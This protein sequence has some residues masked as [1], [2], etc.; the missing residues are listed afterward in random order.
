[1]FG[2]NSL[3]LICLNDF[4]IFTSQWN[5]GA[6][7]IFFA[8]FFYRFVFKYCTKV[9][10]QFFQKKIFFLFFTS[11]KVLNKML[12]KSISD[13]TVMQMFKDCFL[14]NYLRKMLCII[15]HHFLKI[16][17]LLCVIVLISIMVRRNPNSSL[18][19]SSFPTR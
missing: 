11:R 13:H 17:K 16:K 8:T 18:F 14:C 5:T 3:L 7:Q 12:I 4:T 9:F 2:S 19:S 15:K 6:K 10:Q 1:M